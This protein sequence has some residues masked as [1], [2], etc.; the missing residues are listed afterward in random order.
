MTTQ[1]KSAPK[2]TAIAKRDGTPEPDRLAL[3][4]SVGEWYYVAKQQLDALYLSASAMRDELRRPGSP[5]G[6]VLSAG[7]VCELVEAL[8]KATDALGGLRPPPAFTIPNP[9][10]TARLIADRTAV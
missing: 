8:D 4:A 9:V 2:T 1:K 7:L 10:A 5:L 6:E 3:L